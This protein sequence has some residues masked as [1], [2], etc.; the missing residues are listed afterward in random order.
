M[1]GRF[2][3]FFLYCH[4]VCQY[5]VCNVAGEPIFYVLPYRQ[6]GTH[7]VEL[8]PATHLNLT[9]WAAL[10]RRA[11]RLS[12]SGQELTTSARR[13]AQARLVAIFTAF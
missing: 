1:Q 13:A 7:S 9:R 10:E 12:V 5:L 6:H 8:P 2:F 11:L 3:R 4:L